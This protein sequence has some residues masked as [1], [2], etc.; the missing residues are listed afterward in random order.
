MC[1]TVNSIMMRLWTE[2][3]TS[4]NELQK[5]SITVAIYTSDVYINIRYLCELSEKLNFEPHDTSKTKCYRIY[6]F[7]RQA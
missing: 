3:A 6:F 7:V 4:K 1:A 2:V 5:T